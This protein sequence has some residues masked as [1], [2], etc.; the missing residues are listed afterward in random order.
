MALGFSVAGAGF[1][2]AWGRWY[3]IGG[4]WR[5]EFAFDEI[6]DDF[7]HLL[8]LIV[9]GFPVMAVIDSPPLA[10]HLIIGVLAPRVRLSAKR[11]RLPASNE[12]DHVD[13]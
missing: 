13:A 7:G 6:L 10:D 5:L 11:P 1:P 3:D 4:R 8:V 9:S 2:S 12:V